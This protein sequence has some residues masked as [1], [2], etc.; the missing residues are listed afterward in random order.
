MARQSFANAAKAP[1]KQMELSDVL[2]PEGLGR[3][4][5]FFHYA[6]SDIWRDPA[7]KKERRAE[8]Q[9][10]LFFCHQLKNEQQGSYRSPEAH[11]DTY[12]TALLALERVFDIEDLQAESMDLWAA[13]LKKWLEIY[14]E[15]ALRLMEEVFIPRHD[16][17]ID[18]LTSEILSLPPKVKRSYPGEFMDLLEEISRA[19]AADPMIATAWKHTAIRWSQ[20]NLDAAQEA[21]RQCF[22]IIPGTQNSQNW[23]SPLWPTILKAAQ[24]LDVPFRGDEH[25]IGQLLKEGFEPR[26]RLQGLAFPHREP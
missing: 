12:Y 5:D 24:D 7:L 20:R 21:V 2:H 25:V 19:G 11:S 18:F 16:M 14:P 9:G 3:V 23:N 6:R 10:I 8:A 15:E 17:P 26:C 22:L 4:F 1:L 13:L